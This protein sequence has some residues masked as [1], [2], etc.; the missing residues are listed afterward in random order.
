MKRVN[1]WEF[2]SLK[3]A[4]FAAIFYFAYAYIRFGSLSAVSHYVRQNYGTTSS[5]QSGGGIMLEFLP[6]II[7]AYLACV[8]YNYLGLRIQ[9][10]LRAKNK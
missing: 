1:I 7:C 9:E 2:D 4:V 5:Q 10:R 6:V 8:L 3:F